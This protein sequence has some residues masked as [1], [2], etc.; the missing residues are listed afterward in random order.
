[1]T[2]HLPIWVDELPAD[3]V[4]E[5]PRLQPAIEHHCRI[6]VIQRIIAGPTA[7]HLLID[8]RRPYTKPPIKP[9]R[10]E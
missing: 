4:F 9:E 8:I 5:G 1:M 10:P 2:E 7:C 3:F 6:G